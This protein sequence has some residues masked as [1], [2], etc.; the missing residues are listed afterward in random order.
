MAVGRAGEDER[1]A[2]APCRAPPRCSCAGPA[3]SAFSCWSLRRLKSSSRKPGSESCG[4]AIAAKR[5]QLSRWTRAVKVVISLSTL[6]VEARGHREERLLDLVDRASRASR[7]RRSSRRTRAARPSLPFGS[8][9]EPAAKSS[10]TS[11]CGSVERRTRG[12]RSAAGPAAAGGGPTGEARRRPRPRRPAARATRAP[13]SSRSP[14]AAGPSR[15]SSARAPASTKYFL[16][17]AWRSAGVT[18]VV[19]RGRAR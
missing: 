5:S 14:R 12:S 4:S 7:R 6:R 17:A 19:G 11:S 10:F 9:A 8:W 13:G 16:A 2:G 3:S 1:S 18:G 15:G